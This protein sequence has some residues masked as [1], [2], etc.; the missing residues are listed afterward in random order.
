MFSFLGRIYRGIIVPC[1]HVLFVA[2]VIWAVGTALFYALLPHINSVLEWATGADFGP[3][4][5]P[6]ERAVIGLVSGFVLASAVLAYRR[7]LIIR[8]RFRHVLGEIR[9]SF[10]EH[11]QFCERLSAMTRSKS[12]M[13]R[14]EASKRAREYLIELCG[15]ISSVCAILTQSP[16]HTSVKSFDPTTG[17]VTTRA[18]D[19]LVHNRERGEVDEGLKSFHYEENTAFEKIINDDSYYLY[20]CNWLRLADVAG[21]Y[22]NRNPEWKKFYH[23]TIV[24]PITLNRN[25]SA[26]NKQSVIGFVCVDNMR[27]GF[28]MKLSRAVLLIFVVMLHHTVILLGWDDPTILGADEHA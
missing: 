27:G 8:R 26:I 21:Y 4:L 3:A 15:N 19:A 5:A 23:A 11:L 17:L 16:C 28:N 24:L 10:E 7:V 14:S 18:R 25:A 6:S 1:Y 13:V 9:H 20:R 22:K 12:V 2:A